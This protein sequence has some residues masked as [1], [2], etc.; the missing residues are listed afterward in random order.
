TWPGRTPTPSS[1]SWTPT[2]PPM[3]SMRA[4]PRRTSSSCTTR[5][6]SGPTA[7]PQCR[8]TS[9]KSKMPYKKPFATSPPVRTTTS[10]Q[11]H[12]PLVPDHHCRTDHLRRRETT[13]RPGPRKHPDGTFDRRYRCWP[14]NLHGKWRYHLLFNGHVIAT[15]HSWSALQATA[16]EH[17]A[18]L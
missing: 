1:S 10:E 14:E 4:S 5:P 12:R 2:S 13:M 9:Q 3:A 17:A 11:P 7:T 15:E 8:H 16:E 6:S 18:C